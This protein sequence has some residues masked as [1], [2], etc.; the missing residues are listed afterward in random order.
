MG[1]PVVIEEIFPLKC[2]PDELAEFLDISTVEHESGLVYSGESGGI[3]E[4][5][6]DV[7]APLDYR[8]DRGV[9]EVAER[10]F[11]DRREL[12]LVTYD[13]GPLLAA[14]GPARRPPPTNP[15]SSSVSFPRGG[16]GRDVGGVVR[17][18]G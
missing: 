7:V 17:V 11:F 15:V 2:S 1:K 18:R 9:V 3:N 14:G 10:A 5:L 16:G 4:S 6:S 13:I 8:I 12:T